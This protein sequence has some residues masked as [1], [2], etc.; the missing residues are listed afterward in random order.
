MSE[1]D[2]IEF[3]KMINNDKKKSQTLLKKRVNQWSHEMKKTFTNSPDEMVPHFYGDRF[4]PRRYALKHKDT[5]ETFLFMGEKEDFLNSKLSSNYLRYKGLKVAINNSFGVKQRR[6]LEFADLSAKSSFL[7]DHNVLPSVPNY[8]FIYG[9]LNGF[10]WP[11]APRKKFLACADTTHDLPN[12]DMFTDTNLIDW[13]VDGQIAASFGEELVLWSPSLD[14]TLIYKMSDSS[15]IAYCPRG[16]YLAI[17]SKKFEYP[18]IELWDVKNK[19]ELVISNGYYFC[20]RQNCMALC[21]EWAQNGK[22]VVCGTNLGWV[23]VF[24]VPDLDAIRVFKNHQ[25]SV[26]MIKFSPNMRYIATSDIEGNTYIYNWP[27]CD[28]H[29]VLRSKRKLRVVIDWHPWNGTDLAISEDS[30]ASIV[31]LHVPSRE[32]VAYYQRKDRRVEIDFITFNKLTAELLVSFSK[33]DDDG[34]VTS[35]ILVMSSLDRVVDVLRVTDSSVRFMMWSPTGMQLATAGNDETL[36]IWNFLPNRNENSLG[37]P[38]VEKMRKIFPAVR[39]SKC[40]FDLSYGSEFKKW[41]QMK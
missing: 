5:N 29:V 10:D 15:S 35:E 6:M 8:E 22:V 1:C 39:K 40:A 11:C 13:S 3:V 31:I 25:Q 18:V 7:S 38:V 14:L 19:T 16:K 30:P 2:A 36:T 12:F 33:K 4:I 21:I 20:K 32:I 24:N 37:R 17:A 27:S 28:I 41:A 26:Y 23:Y 34:C 9:N